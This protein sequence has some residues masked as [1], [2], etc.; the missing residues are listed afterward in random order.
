[1]NAWFRAGAVFAAAMLAL[2]CSTEV[3]TFDGGGGSNTGGAGGAANPA[4]CPASDLAIGTSCNFDDTNNVNCAYQHEGCVTQVTC[5]LGEWF[6]V[7][8]LG[9]CA[10][11]P[12]T[13]PQ[14]GSACSDVKIGCPYDVD[15]GCGSTLQIASCEVEGWQLS[16]VACP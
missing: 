14:Q 11:C 10:N 8:T 3:E 1:M 5:N 16:P 13:L 15:I 12:D 6:S 2:N 9:A 4:G 7:G